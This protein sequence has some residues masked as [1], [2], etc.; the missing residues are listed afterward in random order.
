MKKLFTAAVVLAALTMISMTTNANPAGVAWQNISQ[1]LEDAPKQKKLILLDLYTDWCGWCKR[2]DKDTYADST[3]AAYL[4][5]HYI[6]SKMNP[7]KDGKVSYKGEEF[8]QKE[9]GQA[10]GVNSY[11]STAFFNEK[12]E[13]LTI[14]P[15]YIGAKEFLQILKFFGD[16]AYLNT[17]WE[18]Y[19]GKSK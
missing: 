13:L 1:A 4:G 2:M 11:P 5:Q 18:E 12:G 6:S 19:S 16:G 3:V 15:G 8:T 10:L 17:T 7:E 14:V 9:F